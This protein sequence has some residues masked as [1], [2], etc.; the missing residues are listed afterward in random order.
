MVTAED[1]V[2]DSSLNSIPEIQVVPKQW[3]LEACKPSRMSFCAVL[4]EIPP[5]QY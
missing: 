3:K 2:M 1:A 4:S 5:Y